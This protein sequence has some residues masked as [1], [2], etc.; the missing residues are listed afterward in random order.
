MGKCK[1]L[2]TML[3]AV[4]LCCTMLPFTAFADG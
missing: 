2:L 3:L 4:V 1:R